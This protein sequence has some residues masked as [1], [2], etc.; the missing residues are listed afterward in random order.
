MVA[1]HHLVF[2]AFIDVNNVIIHYTYLVALGR[3]NIT[4]DEFV[5]LRKRGSLILKLFIRCEQVLGLDAFIRFYH[6][7][8]RNLVTRLGDLQHTMNQHPMPHR[9]SRV[10]IEV[11]VTIAVSSRILLVSPL[12]A[13][14]ER[15]DR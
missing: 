15:D 11:L 4:L 2:P 14:V 13:L 1:G 7:G 12:P 8:I 5:R 6:A 9:F 3:D 10:G